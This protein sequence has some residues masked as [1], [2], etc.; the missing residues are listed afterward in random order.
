MGWGDARL[1][2]C[3]REH[4]ADAD[5]GDLG[6]QIDAE[7]RREGENRTRERTGNVESRRR[8]SDVAAA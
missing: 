1:G 5:A 3:K 8:A 7:G 6:E 4:A 2:A